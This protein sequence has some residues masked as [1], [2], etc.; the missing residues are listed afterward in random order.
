MTIEIKNRYTGDVICSG[1][2]VLAAVKSLEQPYNLHGADLSDASLSGADLHRADLHRANLSGASLSGA[3][4]SGADLR[5]A[6]LRDANLSGASLSGADLR[7]AS[8]RGADLSDASLSGA[9]LSGADLR[10]ASLRGADL[11]DASLSG[12]DLS[13]ASL[14]GANICWMSHALVAEIGARGADNDIERLKTV[15]LIAFKT[16]WCWDTF[17]KID[18][19]HKEWLL[20]VL[21][22]WVKEGDNAPNCLRERADKLKSSE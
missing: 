4:L 21:A 3:S 18:D 17:M 10:G 20:D 11:S 22:P 13:G 5:G 16:G 1:E 8:L 12:A 15:A 14:S 7:G 9:S 19:P 2:T 6:N